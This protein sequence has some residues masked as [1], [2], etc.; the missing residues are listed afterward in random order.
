MSLVNTFCGS[1]D[2]HIKTNRALFPLRRTIPQYKPASWGNYLS[3]N[4][5]SDKN[6]GQPNWIKAT[7]NLLSL[8]AYLLCSCEC[9]AASSSASLLQEESGK[10]LFWTGEV[11]TGT[12]IFISS[13][14]TAFKCTQ[15]FLFSIVHQWNICSLYISPLFPVLVDGPSVLWENLSG[16]VSIRSGPN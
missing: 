13:V 6:P 4:M 11:S 8:S 9:K 7:L 15:K 12:G 14:T 1:R 10:W 16:R 5:H 3:R 2:R